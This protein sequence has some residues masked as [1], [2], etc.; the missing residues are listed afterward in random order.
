ME[1][2]ELKTLFELAYLPFYKQQLEYTLK[3]MQEAFENVEEKDLVFAEAVYNMIDKLQTEEGMYKVFCDTVV[4]HINLLNKTEQKSL[5]SYV[6]GAS[7]FQKVESAGKYRV[8]D[9]NDNSNYSLNLNEVELII[10][11][12]IDPSNIIKIQTTLPQTPLG[13]IEITNN[14]NSNSSTPSINNANTVI[15]LNNNSSIELINGGIKLPIGLNQI[16]TGDNN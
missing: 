2:K 8:T 9:V 13:N 14:Q 10:T 1:E 12:A 3:P 7:L 16:E 15:A 5:L 4:P 6:K 11:E